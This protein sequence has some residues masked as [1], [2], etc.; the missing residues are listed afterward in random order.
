MQKLIRNGCVAVL[1]SPGHGAGWSTWNNEYSDELMFDPG[2]VDLIESG[3]EIEKVEA[4]ATLKWPDIY[5]GGLDGLTI[6]WV[7]QGTAFRVQEY[8]GAESIE[9][10]D[11]IAWTIA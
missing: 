11:N 3:A 7:P 10:C 1:Y 9:I 5:L 8:D 4:Y 2:L 6:E